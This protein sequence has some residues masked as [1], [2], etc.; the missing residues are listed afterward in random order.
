MKN[1]FSVVKNSG[2]FTVKRAL[3]AGGAIVILVLGS[4]LASKG[5]QE[6]LEDVEDQ[7][8]TELEGEVIAE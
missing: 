3:V 4:Y 5:N 6:Y 7:E 2:V 1:L 8:I